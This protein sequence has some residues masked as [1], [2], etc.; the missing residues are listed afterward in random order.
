MGYTEDLSGLTSPVLLK[1]ERKITNLGSARI[2][3]GLL[4]VG[5]VLLSSRAPIGYLAITQMPVAVNQG[6][7]AMVCDKNI[8][9]LFAWLWTEANMGVIKQ[10]ANGSTFQEISKSSFRPIPI[11]LP[12]M[13]TLASFDTMVQPLYKKILVN[14][15]ASA[16]LAEMRDLLLPALLS[17]EVGIRDAE[18]AVETVL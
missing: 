17:G 4:P 18:R 14:E 3:S 6:I 13:V 8:S 16:S 1:T 7:I 15:I 5:T 10:K 2:G 9:N 12:P 11:I